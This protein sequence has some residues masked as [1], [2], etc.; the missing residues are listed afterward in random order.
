MADGYRYQVTL[1]NYDK[2]RKGELKLYL[3]ILH[4][5]AGDNVL[6]KFVDAAVGDEHPVVYQTNNKMDALRVAHMLTSKGGTP[7]VLGLDDAE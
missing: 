2:D 5:K 4:P 7:D 6:T 1:E 3:K